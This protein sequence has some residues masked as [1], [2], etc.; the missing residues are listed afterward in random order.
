MPSHPSLQDVS[1]S[2]RIFLESGVV[3]VIAA[4]L[5]VFIFLSVFLP[6]F[7]PLS[8]SHPVPQYCFIPMLEGKEVG[9]RAVP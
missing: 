1:F 3:T 4:A 8:H 7:P 9:F 5:W 6:P 2:L